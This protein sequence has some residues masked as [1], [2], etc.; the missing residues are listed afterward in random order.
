MVHVVETV[1]RVDALL[2]ERPVVRG[3]IDELLT[4]LVDRL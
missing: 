3:E 1:E 2:R 4:G